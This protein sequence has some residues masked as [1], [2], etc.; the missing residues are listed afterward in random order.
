MVGQHL[1]ALLACDS[2]ESIVEYMKNDLPAATVTRCDEIVKEVMELDIQVT[3][4]SSAQL[5]SSFE[6]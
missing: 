6:Y 2:F 5:S 4:S 3:L 1:D